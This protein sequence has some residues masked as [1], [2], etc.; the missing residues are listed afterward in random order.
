MFHIKI[1]LPTRQ[2]HSEAGT[3]LPQD[4]QKVHIFSIQKTIFSTQYLIKSY[5]KSQ[6][7][8]YVPMPGLFRPKTSKVFDLRFTVATFVARHSN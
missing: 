2:L 4:A 7:T 1:T 6:S 8:I 3:P 5:H